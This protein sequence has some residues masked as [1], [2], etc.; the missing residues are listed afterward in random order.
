LFNVVQQP[1]PE[2]NPQPVLKGLCADGP[3]VLPSLLLCD[4][5]D[6][7]TEVARLER[8][9]VRA[10]HLDVMDGQFVPNLS[11]GF[12]IVEAVRRLTDLPLD[13]HLMI[14]EPER[15]ARQFVEAGANNVTI[16]IE[17]ADDP[18]P[19]LKQIRAA[20]ASAGLALNPDTPL[21]RIEPFLDD[22][23]VVL[24]MSVMPGFGGQSF[25][26]VALDKLRSL[27]RLN[28]GR[29]TL[30]VDGGVNDK[31]IGDCGAA[32]ADLLVVG[33][34]IFH[35]TDYTASVAR[36]TGLARSQA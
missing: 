2:A 6:L 11:Y 35:Q 24:V 25:E 13:C 23:D 30:E 5:G 32:G 22:C 20:G 17:A 28:G 34:A 4:F 12:P 14:V 33:S 31:T 26:R 36:L 7:R 8:A 21:S 10:L 15:Y 16:H 3:V 18:R 29:L 1:A 27:R 9:G 19:V